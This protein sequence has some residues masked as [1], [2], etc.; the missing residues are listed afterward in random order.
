VAALDLGGTHLRTAVVLPDGALG[1]RRHARTPV[2]DGPDAVMEAARASLEA[3]IADHVAAGGVAPCVLGISAPGPLDPRSGV[4]VEPPNLGRAFWG[5]PL[6]GSLADALGLSVAIGLDTQVALLAE[7][8][9]GAGI[10]HDDLVYLTVSTGVGGSIMTGGRLITGPDGVA[11]ELGHLTVDMDGPLCGCGVPGHLERV[12][13]GSGM[14]RSALE[15]LEKNGDAA[16]ELASIATQIAPRAL[17][18]R[19]VSLAAERGDP[20]AMDIVARARRGFAAAVVSIVDVFN[21]DRVIVGGGIAMAWGESLLGPARG[22]LAR[23]AYRVA[24]Q[25]VEIVPA[26]LGDDV[27]LVGAV[28]LVGMALAVHAPGFQGS[29]AITTTR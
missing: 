6:G 12:S 23:S 16:P 5:M 10:G 26:T 15:A 1:G 27:G 7:H 22:L 20:I 14:A 17:E 21:P 29:G 28:P 18:A 25:R 19:D 13:S 24:A 9:F 11:G 3:S 8:A 2:A 4:L